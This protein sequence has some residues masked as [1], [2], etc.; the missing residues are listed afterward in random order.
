ME[1]KQAWIL[2]YFW[3]LLSHILEICGEKGNTQAIL[4]YPT[5]KGYLSIEPDILIPTFYRINNVC[6]FPSWIT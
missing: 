6:N 1:V 3:V 4:A 5:A 2:Y